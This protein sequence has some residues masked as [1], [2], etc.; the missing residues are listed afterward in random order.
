MY[1]SQIDI[2]ALQSYVFLCRNDIFYCMKIKSEQII[3]VRNLNLGSFE[4][5]KAFDIVIILHQYDQG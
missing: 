1:L 2:K 4:F 3:R 5:M